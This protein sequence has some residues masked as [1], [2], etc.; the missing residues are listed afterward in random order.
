MTGDD[1]VQFLSETA[2]ALTPGSSLFPTMST[3]TLT[4]SQ[5]KDSLLPIHKEVMCSS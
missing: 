3:S 2:A 1:L 5:Q 4:V